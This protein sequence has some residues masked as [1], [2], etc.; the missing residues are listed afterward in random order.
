MSRDF[1]CVGVVVDAKPEAVDFYRKYGF[2]ELETVLGRPGDRPE[3]TAMF[4]E[5]GALRNS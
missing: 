2:F 5:I 1:G 4:L 3:P